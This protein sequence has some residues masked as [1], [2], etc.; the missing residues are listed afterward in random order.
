MATIY[1]ATT[2]AINGTTHVAWA[3]SEGAA[4]KAKR[5]LAAKHNLKPLKEV[6]HEPV[7]IP[8]SKAGL[9]EWLN[10]NYFTE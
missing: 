1:K 8:T 3:S 10:E 6:F 7:E 5:E 2:V 4:K 9:I